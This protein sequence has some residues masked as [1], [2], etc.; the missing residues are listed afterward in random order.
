MTK[1][2]LE[3]LLT[4]A[5]GPN[6]RIEFELSGG[7][8]SRVFVVRDLSLDRRIVVKAFHEELAESFSI[9]R[10]NREIM[11]SAGMQHPNIVPVLGAGIAG[12]A[13]YFTMPFV[14][15]QSLRELIQSRGRLGTREAIGIL[16]GVAQALAYAHE[17]GIVHRDIKPANVLIS[18]GAAVL[19]DFGVAKALGAG[20]TGGGADLTRAGTSLGTPTYMAPEQVAAEQVDHRTDIY[21]FGVMAFEMVT[22][23][24][25]FTG[26]I[27]TV[28]AAHLSQPAPSAATMRD[29]IPAPLGNL[30]SRC[31]AKE[32]G[33]RPQ[34]A[35]ELV[36]ILED[37]ET[38]SGVVETTVVKVRPGKRTAGLLLALMG[39]VAAVIMVWAALSNES[40]PA[41]GPAPGT[42]AVL[43]FANVGADTSDAYF[44]SGMTDELIGQLSRVAG[45]RVASRT[46][47]LAIDRDLSAEDIGRRLK[48]GS[49]IEGTVRVAGDRLRVTVQLVSTSDGF[50]LWSESFD[51][52]MSDVFDVQDSIASAVAGALRTRSASSAAQLAAERTDVANYDKYLQG[53]YF[54]RRRGADGLERARQLFT[55]VVEADSSFAPAWASLASVYHLLPL[56]T[57][58]PV[59]S[60]REPGRRAAR[61][62]INLDP[63]LAEAHAAL[64]ELRLLDWEFDAAI[65]SLQR[66]LELDPGNTTARQWLGEAYAVTGQLAMAIRELGTAASEDPLSPVIAASHS[67]ALAADRRVNEAVSEAQRAVNIDSARALP[68]MML[69]TVH[70][71]AGNATLA[72]PTLERAAALSGNAPIVLGL[73]GYGYAGIGD[74]TRAMQTLQSLDGPAERG[75]ASARGRVELGLGNL[76]A[77]LNELGNAVRA[78]DPVF[79]VEILS[80]PLYDP[81]RGNP[82]FVE[83]VRLI[84][85]PSAVAEP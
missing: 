51:A 53:R 44:A 11:V 17:R 73:L 57:S 6:H 39:V 3:D 34:S 63:D 62:A 71:Y 72:V 50:T 13:P 82:G 76:D 56:Y 52:D 59:D 9:E 32:P 55:E 75:F 78:H 80:S 40:E 77:A 30:I 49:L 23:A 64:G 84:G 18:S 14:E 45:L 7:G 37:P 67:L 46:S 2:R 65:Q 22:G 25:P 41:D 68:W 61:A 85:L 28:L 31:M 24:P 83:L 35:S 60:V 5:L 21:S 70:L 12:A 19:T 36:E 69:G 81:I 1:D 74:S 10:F 15:G 58:V 8:M 33:D 16:R 66:A 43:P 47:S 26:S 27:Q 54:L 20:S 42:I 79:S 48:V 4:K 29:D 38:S